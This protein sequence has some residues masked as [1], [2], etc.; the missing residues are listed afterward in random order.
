[1]DQDPNREERLNIEADALCALIREEAIG[2][3]GSRPSCPHWDLE[4]CSMHTKGDTVTSKMKTHME[5]QLHDKNMLKYL[6]EHEVW[7]ENQF[8]EID[9]TALKR[10]GR[11]RQT[12]IAKVCHSMWHTGLKHTLYCHEPRPYYMCGEEKEE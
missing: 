8:D 4:V 7:T 5:S 3:R 12:A 1:V 9:E 11:S 2:P 10:M 6:I